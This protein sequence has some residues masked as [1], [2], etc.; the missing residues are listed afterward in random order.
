LETDGY[1][2]L[3]IPEESNFASTLWHGVRGIGRHHVLQEEQKTTNVELW[4]NQW[5]GPFAV[6]VG[7]WK[8]RNKW[9]ETDT[10]VFSR[11]QVIDYFDRQ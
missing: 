11:D 1:P 6:F 2:R 5:V 9:R 4:I 10:R 8:I 7:D 3:N